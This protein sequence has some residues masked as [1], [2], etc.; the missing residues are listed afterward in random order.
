MGTATDVGKTWVAAALV[1]LLIDAGRRVSVRKPVQS[2]APDE[3]TTDADVLAA[4]TGEDPQQ[5][6]PLGRRYRLAM[7][8]PVAAHRLGAAP[9]ALHDLQAE[10]TWP[11]GIEIGIVETVGGVRSP[12]ADDGDSAAFAQSIPPDHV[13]LVADAGLGAINAVRLSAGAL[14]P[15]PVTVMLNRFDGD[16]EVHETNRQWLADRD[17][18]AV[19]TSVDECAAELLRLLPIEGT[20][21]GGRL[22]A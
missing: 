3:L 9:I 18:F 12:M 22:P 4:A 11:E 10:L 7:A 16:N 15:L 8:P 5:V 17:G 14:L 21:P 2:F 6:C 13:L 19:V 20:D 1:R